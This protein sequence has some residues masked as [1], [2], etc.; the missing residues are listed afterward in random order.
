MK[1]YGGVDVYL[2]AFFTLV[3]DGPQLQAPVA[4]PCGSI[5]QYSLNSRLGGSKNDF[6]RF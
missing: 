6:R 4:L 1:A 2:H 5:R 3:P